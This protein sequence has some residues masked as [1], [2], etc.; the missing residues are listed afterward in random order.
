ML[1][2]LTLLAGC[3][4]W[5]ER[6]LREQ[7]PTPYV[8]CVA[9]AP[10]KARAGELGGVSYTLREREL[11]LSHSATGLRLGVFAAA[12]IGGP[13]DVAAL[14]T[15]RSAQADVLLLLGGLGE[16]GDQA[17]A[18]AKALAGLGRLVLVVLGGRD[19]FR[20]SAEALEALGEEA[21]VLD[22]TSLRGIKIGKDTLIPWGGAEQGRYA[23]DETRCGFGARDVQELAQALGTTPVGERRWLASWQALPPASERAAVRDGR[24]LGAELVQ[25]AERLGVRGSFAAWAGDRTEVTAPGPVGDLLV[26]RA[27]GPPLELADGTIVPNGVRVLSFQSDGPLLTR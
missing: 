7:G 21:P 27:W 25:L 17:R 23:L 18:S 6:Q 2:L 10:P 12:G 16:A 3:N 22:V 24:E 8:R 26:P 5:S 1:C 14:Q 4:A 9:G 15:L 20:S 13:P 19:G 11:V